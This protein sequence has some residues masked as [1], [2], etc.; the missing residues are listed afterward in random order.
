[1]TFA[2]VEDARRVLHAHLAPTRLVPAEALARRVGGRVYLKLETDLPT[3]S[4]KPRGA[5]Y[6]L[7]ACRQRGPVA[8]VVAASTGNH[9]AAVAYAAR[10]LGLPATIFL[11]R[12]PNPVKRARIAAQGAR[13]IEGGADLAEAAQAARAHAAATGAYFLDDATDPDLPAGAATIACEIVE[14]TQDTA[15]LYVP[16]GDTA[17]IRGVAL[18]ARHLRPG[19]RIVGVQAEGAPAYA[20]SWRAGRPVP[21]PTCQTIADG[22]A[23]RTPV[24]AN[25]AAIRRLVDDVRL[26]S[27]EAMLAAIR[28]LLLDEH[29]VAEPAGAAATAAL[30]AEDRP[31]AG[32]VVLLVT[33]ANIAPEVLRRAVAG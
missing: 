4:F 7:W 19:I 17:L 28:V 3:G 16:V 33:G 6:A 22:L 12:N 13:V 23:T 32:P 26:V 15:A 10:L 30:L 11:P 25:V 20:L 29:V 8:E 2:Q 9:G 18:A 21:T 14:Q 27:D 31:P 5:L 24:A 1:M